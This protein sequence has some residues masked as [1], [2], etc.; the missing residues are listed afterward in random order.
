LG[1]KPSDKLWDP[2]GINKHQSLRHQTL[3]LETQKWVDPVVYTGSEKRLQGLTGNDLRD[4]IRQHASKIYIST[5]TWVHD[6]ETRREIV[7]K[8]SSGSTKFRV[9]RA[10]V[11][12][13]RHSWTK[14]NISTL[15]KPRRKTSPRK[16]KL[17]MRQTECSPLQWSSTPE[18]E[19]MAANL[20][21]EPCF[22]TSI[23]AARKEL[24]HYFWWKKPD[25][26]NKT[27]FEVSENNIE[28]T[29]TIN[30]NQGNDTKGMD[31]DIMVVTG[32][33]LTI[34]QETH[35]GDDSIYV[36]ALESFPTDAAR[37]C[38]W[39]WIWPGLTTTANYYF[40]QDGDQ[41]L[42][43]ADGLE[44]SIYWNIFEVFLLST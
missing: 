38:Y 6:E 18:T 30:V 4:A 29:Q 1:R 20:E 12:S 26:S 3:L 11:F 7:K 27:F 22:Q 42:S 44:N 32:N 15:K 9:F 31:I 39:D 33:A 28:P 13:N 5:G 2:K 19:P 36:D 24:Y 41:E 37:S 40:Q 14:P 17:A 16:E 10:F 34:I 21:A 25:S 43:A 8:P 35:H 23:S